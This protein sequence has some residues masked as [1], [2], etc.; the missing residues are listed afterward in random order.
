MGPNTGRNMKSILLVDDN[1]VERRLLYHALKVAYQVREAGDA[2]QASAIAA[3]H[4]PDLVL[5]DLH[6]PPGPKARRRGSPCNAVSRPEIR[7]CRW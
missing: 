7:F 6:L 5:L 1:A 3:E 4:P 2:A